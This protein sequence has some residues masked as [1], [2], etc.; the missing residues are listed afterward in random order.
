[1]AVQWNSL[2]DVTR[3][4]QGY[5]VDPTKIIVLKDLSGRR[6]ETDITSLVASIKANGQEQPAMAWKNDEGWPVLAAGHRRLRSILKL[7]E[8]ITDPEKRTR[9]LFNFI[10]AKTE[11]DAFAYTITE[12]RDR[13]NPS[14]LDDGHNMAI[15]QL[16]FGKSE[17]D[18]AQIY[19]PDIA[20][21]EDLAKAVREVKN[22]LSLLE[23]SPE[24]QEEL[25]KGFFSTS[26]ALQLA[27]IPSR[28]QQNAVIKEA[29]DSG[30]KKI[31]V[32][33][34]REAKEA[35]QGKPEKQR[36][37]SDNSPVKLI[38][39]YKIAMEA[40]GGLAS[41]VLAPYFKK[42][43]DKDVLYELAE[44]VVVM[45]KSLGIPLE[46]SSDKWAEAHKDQETVITNL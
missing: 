33:E 34:A 39:K 30:K 46:A 22:C 10:P 6:D 27:Q 28:V 20:T 37:I 25:R 3:T 44:Q 43:T 18:I 42:T 17:E 16:R 19:Y 45:C 8:G 24:A 29:K 32:E 21:P 23:L 41:E 1:M 15:L 9:L 36:N 31:K 11:V 14:P 35:S 4:G 12:N 26:A 38:K 5:S 13:L 2:A 7:N 40:A